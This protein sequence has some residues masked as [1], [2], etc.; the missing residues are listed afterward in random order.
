MLHY[1]ICPDHSKP[2][3]AMSLKYGKTR[4]QVFFKY[5][6]QAHGIVPLSGTSS[7]QHMAEDLDVATGLSPLT[8][9]EVREI[10]AL[11]V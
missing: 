4:E 11:L 6:Q 2:V 1:G 9:E 5:V 7:A 8:P 3:A 10:D